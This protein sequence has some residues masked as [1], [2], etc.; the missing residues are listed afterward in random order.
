M[1]HPNNDNAKKKARSSFHL[2]ITSNR[3]TVEGQGG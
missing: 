2:Q 1:K 3:K